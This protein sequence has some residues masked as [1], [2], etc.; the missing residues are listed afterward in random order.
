MIKL[1]IPLTP[2][3]VNHY[4]KHRAATVKGKTL[5]MAYPSKDAKAWWKAVDNFTGGASLEAEAYEIAYVV[6]QGKNER[7]DVD[8]YAK[9]VLD[10]LVRS[11]VIDSDHKVVALHSYKRKDRDYPRTEIFIR[12]AGQLNLLAPAMP[13]LEEW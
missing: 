5:V 12:E 1:V 2:P 10:A 8:N 13:S 11:Q 6:Y 9:C 7:G 4:M 3:T